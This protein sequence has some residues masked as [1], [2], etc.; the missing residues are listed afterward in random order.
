MAATASTFVKNIKGKDY[1]QVAGRV[2]MF[3]DKYPNGGI[4]TEW[5]VILENIIAK[6]TIYNDEGQ[7]LASGH[8]TLREALP[9][10]TWK[11][12]E[13]ERAETAALGRALSF[14]GF[15][16]ADLDD[17]DGNL[18]DSP[19][20]PAKTTAAAQPAIVPKSE[21]E[22]P[23]PVAKTTREKLGNDG[24]HKLPVDD[25][26]AKAA[27]FVEW[28]NANRDNPNVPNS[29]KDIL[30][31]AFGVKFVSEI[32]LAQAEMIAKLDAQYPKDASA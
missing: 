11:G 17:D 12:R 9:T 16:T 8:A 10:D 27:A 19:I 18:A 23:K 25:K 24:A 31:A 22:G 3:R 30:E 7:I 20:E 32:P 6:A 1:L 26:Q 5:V 21:P 29:Q 2:I 15:G 13:F 14:A 28:Y 4:R